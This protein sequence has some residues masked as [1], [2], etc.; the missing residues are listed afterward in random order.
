MISIFVGT[1]IHVGYVGHKKSS[2]WPLRLVAKL[3][4]HRF[5]NVRLKHG[6][7]ISTKLVKRRWCE[8]VRAVAVHQQA[9]FV[10]FVIGVASDM[11]APVDHEYLLATSHSEPLGQHGARESCADN[12]PVI[13][14]SVGHVS[15]TFP[16]QSMSQ[17]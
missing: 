10:R 13:Y 16:M 14:S 9:I 8:R 4:Q 17:C 2:P 5:K 12:E 1:L 7:M 11:G 3:G 15:P 6:T